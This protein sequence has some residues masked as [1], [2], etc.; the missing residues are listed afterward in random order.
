MKT[1]NNVLPQGWFSSAFWDGTLSK[2]VVF[3]FP[4]WLWPQDLALSCR[5]FGKGEVETGFAFESGDDVPPS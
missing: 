4:S 3:L 5:A 2:V 1:V